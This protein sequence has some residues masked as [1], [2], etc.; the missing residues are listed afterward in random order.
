MQAGYR[1]RTATVS[2]KKRKQTVVVI[3]RQQCNGPRLVC[4]TVYNNMK[5]TEQMLQQQERAFKRRLW[6]TFQGHCSL[7]SRAAAA[8]NWRGSTA[9]TNTA[10]THYYSAGSQTQDTR[11]SRLWGY[12]LPSWC[13][14]P[15]SPCCMGWFLSLTA[16][17]AAFLHGGPGAVSGG[18]E[19]RE[20]GEPAE[21]SSQLTSARE[22]EPGTAP[23]VITGA[24]THNT[25]RWLCAH[26]FISG[27]S[28]PT[29][30]IFNPQIISFLLGR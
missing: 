27:V 9:R 26:D 17:R 22:I 30:L 25:Q 4:N 16:Q 5:E 12:C 19:R 3:Y 11:R 20:S 28:C 2:G 21:P 23:G 8:F 15:C 14:C 10:A 7:K 1:K 13:S 18:A 29:S 24:A 6:S